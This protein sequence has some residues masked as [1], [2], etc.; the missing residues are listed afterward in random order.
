MPLAAITSHPPV[1]RPPS[2]VV[3][4]PDVLEEAIS[5]HHAGRAVESIQKTLTHLL[6]LQ[7][8]GDLRE[9]PLVIVQGSSRV[10]VR[11]VG[12]EVD[13]RVPMIRL[14]PEGNPTAA[15][16]YLL[17]R[18]A[19]SG[20]LHQPRL[21][22]ENVVLEFRDKLSRLHPLKL[23]EV[24]RRMPV[25][26][27]SVDDWMIDQFGAAALDREPI[28]PLAE[29][30]LQRAE[31]IW[32]A[33]FAEVEELVKESQR[34]RSMFFLNELTAFAIHHLRCSLPLAGAIVTRV[35]EAAAIFNDT[36]Q[37]PNRREAAV[38]KFAKEMRALPRDVLHKNLGHASYAIPPADPGTREVLEANLSAD[39]LETV[40][41]IRTGGHS[42]DATL[43]LVS[44]Y[45][46]LLSKFGWPPEI[47]A[48]L[49]QGLVEVSGKPWRDASAT[50]LA[51]AKELLAS[52]DEDDEETDD[53]ETDEHESAEVAS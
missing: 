10:F 34:K 20:Q 16:R 47:G 25:E 32:D 26:A 2:A 30:E 28:E 19:G 53:E 6:P 50:L 24:L 27:D 52:L 1:R 21:Y 13:V 33:H 8:L 12:D 49:L 15:L 17:G 42:M 46:F 29:D 5:L 37:D 48:S 7:A 39:Y 41:R 40:R 38:A 36:D 44:S 43:A 14:S 35:V 4:D 11:V 3:L 23:L 22:D 9:R 45:S 31:A 51:H 18:V